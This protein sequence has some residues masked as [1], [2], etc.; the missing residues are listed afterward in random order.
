MVSLNSLLFHQIMSYSAWSTV[1]KM[2]TFKQESNKSHLG[3]NQVIPG[4]E[5]VISAFLPYLDRILFALSNYLVVYY[6]IFGF[7]T[8]FFF[9]QVLL[10][11]IA[12]QGHGTYPQLCRCFL[13]SSTLF[14]TFPQ[15]NFCTPQVKIFIVQLQM[16]LL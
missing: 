1:I 7:V 12:T 9:G 3:V 14:K 10:E 2:K 11:L 15:N 4:V 6:I 16:L 8:C 5:P 13:W